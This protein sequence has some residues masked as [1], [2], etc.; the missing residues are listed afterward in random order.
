LRLTISSGE[1]AGTSFEPHGERF[2]LGRDDACDVVLDDE[3]VSRQH[4]AV[5]ELPDG[6][7][8]IEDLGSRNGTFVNGERISEP[9]ELSGGE[10]LTIGRTAINV[11][12][13]PAAA[14]AQVTPTPPP[15]AQPAPPASPAAAA[16]SGKAGGGWRAISAAYAV[17][18]GLIAGGLLAATISLAKDPFC[19]DINSLAEAAGEDECIQ[20]SS[21]SRSVT[22]GFLGLA[23]LAG[24][25]SAL[26]A[27]AFTVTGRN[28][29]PIPFT[30]GAAAVLY[31]IAVAVSVDVVKLQ[32]TVLLGLPGQ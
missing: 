19:S 5:A 30:L 28:W 15:P 14:E 32:S 16:P 20:D 26:L 24:I 17:I 18:F 29:R 1:G 22:V 2:V 11:E 13:I 23:S 8:R 27:L 3:E 31:G 21:G 12:A 7:L 4:A 9:V 6:R 25:A 10:A